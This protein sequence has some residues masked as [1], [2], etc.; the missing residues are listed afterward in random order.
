[1]GLDVP[2]DQWGPLILLHLVHQESPER[3]MES[4][5]P[6]KG[7]LGPLTIDLRQQK[8]EYILTYPKFLHA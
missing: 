8:V 4:D 7:T 3:E 1:M 6:G 2:G 5:P